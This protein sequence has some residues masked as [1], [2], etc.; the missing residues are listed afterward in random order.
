MCN[1]NLSND[2]ERNS[3]PEFNAWLLER[4][5][6]TCGELYKIAM[7]TGTY[8]EYLKMMDWYRNRYDLET[9]NPFLT[10]AVSS[11]NGANT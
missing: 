6:H 3:R 11:G 1:E 2:Q 5:G 10:D 8:Q 7:A 9:N 4:S